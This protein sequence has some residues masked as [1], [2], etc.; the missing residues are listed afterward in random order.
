MLRGS[1]RPQRLAAIDAV[2][3][4]RDDAGAHG[5]TFAPRRQPDETDPEMISALSV[6]VQS[7]PSGGR[8]IVS[9]LQRWCAPISTRDAKMEVAQMATI[10]EEVQIEAPA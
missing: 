7:P 5:T 10:R 2:R 9:R 8:R 6:S 3:A 1:G 4:N